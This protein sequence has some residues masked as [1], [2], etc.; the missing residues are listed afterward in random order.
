MGADRAQKERPEK[1]FA[2]NRKARFDYHIEERFEAG[3]A[4]TGT[5]VKSVRGGR[6]N[7]ADSYADVEV[8]GVTLRQC[9]ISP[10]EAGNRFN[11]DPLRPRRLLLHRAE[12][13]RLWGKVREKGL[14]LVPLSLYQKGRRIKVELA[15]ARGKKA[16]DRRED[17][18]RRTAER[19]MEQAQ[20]ARR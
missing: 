4:L 19:E 9:H 8:D 15:L 13:K 1:V 17:I 18:K 7:L 12:I 5:E 10:Y 11:H 6:A 16:P 3:I 2:S 14:T 20:K